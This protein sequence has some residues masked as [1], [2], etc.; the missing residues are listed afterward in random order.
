MRKNISSAMKPLSC[1]STAFLFFW[2]WLFPQWKVLLRRVDGLFR[3]GHH[4]SPQGSAGGRL[5]ASARRTKPRRRSADA[6]LFAR[7]RRWKERAVYEKNSRR[8]CRRNHGRGEFS[9]EGKQEK[10]RKKQNFFGKF[11]V[12]DNYVIFL[13]KW[14]AAGE[15]WIRKW[16]SNRGRKPVKAVGIRL[17]YLPINIR[18]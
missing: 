1:R 13:E 18:N 17:R 7:K 10:N 3:R 8:P 2:A 16:I 11:F 4:A 15:K 14:K 5:P 12:L 6:R 9:T